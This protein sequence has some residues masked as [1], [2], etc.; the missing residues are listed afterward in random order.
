MG[1]TAKL[2]GIAGIF[3]ALGAVKNVAGWL[4]WVPGFGAIPGIVSAVVGFVLGFVRRFFEGIEKILAN[5][6]TLVTFGSLAFV[7]F[8]LG[9]KLGVEFTDHRYR[10]A[11]ADNARLLEERKVAHAQAEDRA[12]AADRA[13]KEAEA[14]ASR[15][16]DAEAAASRARRAAVAAGRLRSSEPAKPASGGGSGLSWA[17]TIFSGH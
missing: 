17:E 8:A 11:Q 14:A 3:K 4:S 10:E 5:P 9:L 2:A 7:V 16:A 1:L 12:A 15:A 6:V 13:R